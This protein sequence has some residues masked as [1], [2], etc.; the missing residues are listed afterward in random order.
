MKPRRGRTSA[1]PLKGKA[2]TQ[3][4]E[5]AR[6][7]MQR[8]QWEREIEI[9][10]ARTRTKLQHAQNSLQANV[11]DLLGGTAPPELAI[12]GIIHAV[13]ARWVYRELVTAYEVDATIA[14]PDDLLRWLQ[15]R[16]VAE[17][18]QAALFTSNPVHALMQAYVV[19]TYAD[20]FEQLRRVVERINSTKE[21]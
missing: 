20:E 12:S 18:R 10:R 9:L 1:L 7:T 8:E 13:A 3:A 21:E 15:G 14:N 11:E 19:Q 4:Q 17:A 6:L 2:Q 16:C 5:V